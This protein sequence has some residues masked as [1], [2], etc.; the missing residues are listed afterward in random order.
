MTAG[1]TSLV[2]SKKISM[3]LYVSLQSEM[4]SEHEREGSLG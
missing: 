3:S 1:S 4:F 2:K